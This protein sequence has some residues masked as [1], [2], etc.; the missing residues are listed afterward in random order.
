MDKQCGNC[1]TNQ[2][3]LFLNCGGGVSVNLLPCP[4]CGGPAYMSHRGNHHC[5]KQSILFGCKPCRIEITN[6]ILSG[7]SS[8]EWIIEKSV[9]QWNTRCHK[10]KESGNA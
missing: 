9:E 8:I 3:A 1:E 6:S 10:P 7:R 5:K 4:F 2:F